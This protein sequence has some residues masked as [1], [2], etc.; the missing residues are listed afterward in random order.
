MKKKTVVL[1]ALFIA[2]FCGSGKL[3]Q[4]DT[5]SI[6]AQTGFRNGYL[7]ET[8][9]YTLDRYRP[10]IQN[11]LLVTSLGTGLYVE[12]YDI[13]SLRCRNED[14]FGNE[15]IT[16][17]GWSAGG[18][19]LGYSRHDITGS[20][21]YDTYYISAEGPEINGVNPFAGISW[22]QSTDTTVLPSYRVHQV[23]AKSIVSIAGQPVE[24][25]ACVAGIHADE[26]HD[27]INTAMANIRVPIDAG[28]GVTLIP[29]VSYSQPLKKVDNALVTQRCF[30]GVDAKFTIA[31]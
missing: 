29:N 3:V 28:H 9:G 24:V 14:N 7:D 25:S 2:L 19:D 5:F 20:V 27:L 13:R 23:G 1:A 17:C 15:G 26:R 8:T 10:G 4:A 12:L 22:W 16:S 30:V 6:E 11:K 21:K 18:V 31:Y